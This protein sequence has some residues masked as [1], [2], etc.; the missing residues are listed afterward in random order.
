MICKYCGKQNNGVDLYGQ[1]I[2]C[3]SC[4]EIDWHEYDCGC[5]LVH[6]NGFVCEIKGRVK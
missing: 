6:S 4:Q 2:K 3:Q 5:G 1:R